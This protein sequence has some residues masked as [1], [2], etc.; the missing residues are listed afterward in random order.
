MVLNVVFLAVRYVVIVFVQVVFVVDVRV[1]AGRTVTGRS[2]MIAARFG[3]VQHRAMSV[4]RTCRAK[5]TR[6]TSLFGSVETPLPPL[7]L[8]HQT[9]VYVIFTVLRS[10]I[11]RFLIVVQRPVDVAHPFV[12]GPAN[13]HTH[14]HRQRTIYNSNNSNDN[15]TNTINSI[16]VTMTVLLFRGRFPL[17]PAGRRCART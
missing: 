2:R 4:G 8:F 6:M 3:Q 10:K 7:P 14:T 16:R 1:A 5:R 17:G 15:I 12:V 9:Q 11:P 13:T